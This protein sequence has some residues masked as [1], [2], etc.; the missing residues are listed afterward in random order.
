VEPV[1]VVTTTWTIAKTAGEISKK[2]Y[3]FGKGLKDRDAKH[4]IDEILDSVRE[5]KQSASQLEDENREL[6]EKLRFKSSDY[7]FRSP[8]WYDKTQSDRPLCPKCFAKN[9][10]APMGEPG[11]DC[12]SDYRRCLVCGDCVEVSK[13]TRNSRVTMRPGY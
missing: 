13:H 10:A 3:E 8:F 7:E 9:I 2:L 4:K 1:T 12:S 5:L 11:Q 6:R